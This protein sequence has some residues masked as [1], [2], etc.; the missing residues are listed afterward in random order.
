MR[1][2]ILLACA[3]LIGCGEDETAA[4][5]PTEARMDFSHPI[6]F[7]DA[8][9]PSDHRLA[10]DGT[11]D[12][13]SYPNPDAIPFVSTMLT[14]LDGQADGFGQSSGVFFALS[15]AADE[16]TLPSLHDSVEPDASVFLVDID[17]G[18]VDYLARYPVTV[19]FTEDAGPFGDANLLSLVP[20]QGA[21]LRPRTRYAAVV[22][23]AVRDVA[24]QPLAQPETLTR[25]IA[26]DP[27]E[28]MNDTARQTYQAAFGALAELGIALDRLGAVAAFTTWDAT[29]GMTALVDHAR[30]LPTPQP[31]AGWIQTDV[32]D[33]YCVYQSTIEMPVYQRG[34]PP[35]LDD[36]GGITFEE[37]EPVLDRH[38]EARLVVTIPRAPMPAG[39]WPT[40]LM[41]R[42]GGG[43]DRPLVDRGVRD[44]EGVVA[45]PGTGP[46]LHF[47]HAGYAGVTVDGP[48]G[49][50]RNITNDDEQFLIFNI[51][52][53]A[54][55]RDNIRQSALELAL[56]VDVLD[57]Q[58]LDVSDCPGGDNSATFDTNAMTIMGHSM[59]AT[60][61]PLTL[62]TEPRYRAAILSGAGGSW[63]ENVVHKQSPV[64]VRPLA[65]ILLNYLTHQRQLH[66][67]DPVLTLLQWAGEP[68]DPPLFARA[69]TRETDTP[70]HVL[71][72]QG[73]VDTYILPP[74]ANSM[75]L[76]LRLDLAGESLDAAHAELSE[77]RPLEELLV[78]SGAAQIALPAS[79][80]FAGTTAVVIH[81]AEGPI[82][83]GHEVMFQTEPP[84]HQYRCFLDSLRTGTPTVPVGGGED[85]PCGP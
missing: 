60:I 83:D 76:S 68:A 19:E 58:S 85:S 75:S 16:A 17:P 23:T 9:F 55:M 12:M 31:L 34:E 24:G 15:G 18:S 66:D 50:I 41:V 65:E 25:L 6:G 78:H 22:T 63:I 38:E 80:N 2:S 10:E 35:Y 69:I 67:H 21:P 62:A 26:G 53:P 20:L 79:G 52:N 11:V 48:H 56:L 82:E 70:R 49:G 29:S 73:I 40:A 13:S 8:P 39:G 59:G 45:L 54:A 30:T 61:A 81:H 77:F 71:M 46:A 47:T 37:G 33:D 64:A 7:F 36:G 27:A 51:G 84:K 32:F 28:G 3:L 72:L 44:E 5:Q 14:L 74:I 43:G 57:L 1:L 4:P 42:T